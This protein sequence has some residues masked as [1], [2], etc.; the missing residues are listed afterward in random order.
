MELDGMLAAA[1]G[2]KQLT[3]CS[4]CQLAANKYCGTFA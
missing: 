2:H 1:M 3:V 4:E